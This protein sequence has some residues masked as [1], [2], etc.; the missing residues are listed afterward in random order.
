MPAVRGTGYI[1]WCCIKYMQPSQSSSIVLLTCYNVHVIIF[2]CHHVHMIIFKYGLVDYP[3]RWALLTIWIRRVHSRWD[4]FKTVF[5]RCIMCWI[6]QMLK[7]WKL[8]FYQ[9]I[10]NLPLIYW[11]DFFLMPRFRWVPPFYI[12]IAIFSSPYGQIVRLSKLLYF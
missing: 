10:L 12:L 7:I 2:I 9:W 1:W 6:M 3:Q 4:Q 5:W 11:K 8:C